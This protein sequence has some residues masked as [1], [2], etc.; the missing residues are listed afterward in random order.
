M[1]NHACFLHE[2]FFFDLLAN[3]DSFISELCENLAYRYW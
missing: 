3:V 2:L 1:H